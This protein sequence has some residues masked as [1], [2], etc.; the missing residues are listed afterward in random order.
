MG[1]DDEE[2]FDPT[3]E[4]DDHAPHART[5]MRSSIWR[6]AVLQGREPGPRFGGSSLTVEEA[7]VFEAALPL[8]LDG[9]V[10]R[11]AGS[12]WVDD[13]TDA[14]PWHEVPD[15]DRTWFGV[16]PL[17][18]RGRAGKVYSGGELVGDYA[19]GKWIG[20]D[21][22]E[23]EPGVRGLADLWGRIVRD[24]RVCLVRGIPAR[25]P[26]PIPDDEARGL[27][28][29]LGLRRASDAGCGGF[30]AP[31]PIGRRAIVVD[32]DK[33]PAPAWMPQGRAPT[34]DEAQALVRYVADHFLPRAWQGATVAYR[35]TS[36]AGLRGWSTL[37]LHLGLWL[38]RAVYDVSLRRWAAT[39]GRPVDPS[40]CGSVH[41][42]YTAAPLFL[43]GADPLEAAGIPR[44]GLVEG[45]RDEVA[46][47]ASCWSDVHGV[48]PLVA[49][50]AWHEHEHE[51]AARA[52]CDRAVAQAIGAARSI[53]WPAGDLERRLTGY[54]RAALRR[55][56]DGVRGAAQGVA[57]EGRHDT[58]LREARGVGSYVGAG[59]LTRDEVA[60]ALLEAFV[61]VA[62][63]SR[64]GEGAR[65]IKAGLDDSPSVSR[66]ELLARLGS[67]SQA[68]FA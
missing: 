30:L 29:A 5:G 51:E 12:R 46:V 20:V 45:E 14:V 61:A 23:A 26:G 32:V 49:G 55:A 63:G 15:A 39:W 60:A 50:P 28:R 42:I 10:V 43:D 13:D 65:T 64:R 11:W 36:S 57:G 52:A 48:V 22:F 34:R 66:D 2:L 8:R 21:V 67:P 40:T 47:P 44:V 24:Q 59:L 9:S 4:G 68:R 37:S 19:L 18:P 53:G 27:D 35:W 3:G 58:L 54:A 31:H 16:R 62:G 56:C 1:D 7:Q 33:A 6:A 17:S 25:A 41:P 38:E